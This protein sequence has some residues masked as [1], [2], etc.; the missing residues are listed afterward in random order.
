MLIMRYILNKLAVEAAEYI[1][2]DF[3]NNGPPVV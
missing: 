2:N 1:I 3:L